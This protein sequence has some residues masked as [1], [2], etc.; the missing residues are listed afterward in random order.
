MR[1][2]WLPIS[3][4]PIIPSVGSETLSLAED[5]GLKNRREAHINISS[6]AANYLPYR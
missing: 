4:G 5:G 6:L 3:T 2:P 1:C